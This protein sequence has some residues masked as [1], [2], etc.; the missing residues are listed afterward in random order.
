MTIFTNLWSKKENLKY[1]C[2]LDWLLQNLISSL[3]GHQQ[4]YFLFRDQIENI[5]DV[6]PFWNSTP[7][8]LHRWS[9]QQRRKHWSK[10]TELIMHSRGCMWYIPVVRKHTECF[11]MTSQR[12]YWYSKTMKWWPCWLPRP[13]LWELNSFLT[14][15]LSF[16]LI[17]L[18]RC[19]VCEWKRSICQYLYALLPCMIQCLF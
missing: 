13:F 7:R 6:K 4:E 2:F 16:V 18:H 15:M 8:H 1:F 12:L 19:W 17:N 14:Q 10:C 5:L 11:H 9:K 3:Q